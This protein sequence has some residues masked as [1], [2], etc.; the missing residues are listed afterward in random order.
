MI[1]FLFIKTFY[2]SLSFYHFFLL[3]YRCNWWLG[4]DAKLIPVCILWLGIR[5]L[6]MFSVLLFV[7]RVLFIGLIY[8]HKHS[9]YKLSHTLRQTLE[10]SYYIRKIVFYLITD[11]I[12]IKEEVENYEQCRILSY[13]VVISASFLLALWQKS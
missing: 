12:S 8:V 7:F 3:F 1:I 13:N 5:K 4:G 6:M 11:S 9:F 10:K 2:S